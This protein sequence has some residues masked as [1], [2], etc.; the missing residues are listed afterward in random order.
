MQLIRRKARPTQAARPDQEMVDYLSKK[1]IV[2]TPAGDV[3]FHSFCAPTDIQ[4]Y[5]LDDQF[6]ADGNYRSLYTKRASL[7]KI[8]QRSGSNVVLAIEKHN[9]IIGFG[10]LDY[11]EPG[12]RWADMGPGVMME[13]KAIEVCRRW[14]SCKIAPRIIKM[15]LDHPRLEDMIIYL[16]GYSWTWDLEGTK[17]NAQDYRQMLIRLFETFDLKRYETN[18]PNVCLK[19]ENFLMSRIGN[20]I[21]QM[22]RDRFKWLRFGLSPWTWK[23]DE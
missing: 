16:V 23:I 10:T 20:N 4:H 9:C 12:E 21:S 3:L 15:M 2:S 5:V 13:L 1:E 22:V 19:P 11:P 18:E 14:R 6:S 17:M 8:A 7:E